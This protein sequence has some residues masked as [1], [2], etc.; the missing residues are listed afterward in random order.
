M[1]LQWT[2]LNLI[3][4]KDTF[5]PSIPD[6]SL[7]RSLDITNH[8]M[9]PMRNIPQLN[10]SNI[11]RISSKEI[12]HF[13]NHA[14]NQIVKP[15]Q[16]FQLETKTKPKPALINKRKNKLMASTVRFNV[17]KKKKYLNYK[18]NNKKSRSIWDLL[19]IVF[20]MV[21]IFLSLI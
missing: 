2:E 16:K 10:P 14:E 21:F 4:E 19:G 9:P 13:L 12:I 3:G 6:I 1:S 5:I 8:P 7:S 18:S 20:L 15:K 17:P 11:S